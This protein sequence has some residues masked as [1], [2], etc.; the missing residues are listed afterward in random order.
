M[1]G[2][3][4]AI[5]RLQ[6]GTCARPGLQLGLS[7]APVLLALLKATLVSEGPSS[8]SAGLSGCFLGPNWDCAA[9]RKFRNAA[10]GWQDSKV[11]TLLAAFPIFALA[12]ANLHRLP[13]ME[14]HSRILQLQ[15]GSSDEARWFQMLVPL[16][17][18]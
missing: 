16:N 5:S 4:A 14:P 3:P 15:R 6:C 9:A 17:L 11:I 13:Y 2:P 1:P 18:R 12:S 7:S 8:Q 10:A